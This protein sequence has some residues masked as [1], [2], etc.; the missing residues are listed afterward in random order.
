M[1]YPFRS[2]SIASG[3]GDALEEGLRTRK[4]ILAVERKVQAAEAG[5][6]RAQGEYWPQIG[7]SALYSWNDDRFAGGHGDSYTLAAMA[8]W[9]LWNWGATR[10]RVGRSRSDYR[11]ALESQ[12]S[13]RQQVEFEIRQAW[14]AVEEVRA[15]HE[16]SLAGVRAAEKALT[17]LEDRF[18]QGLT[19]TTDLLDAETMAHEA[20]VREMQTRYDLQ[21]ALRTLRYAIGLSPIPEVAAMNSSSL[22]RTYRLFA[23]LVLSIP[24]AAA[25]GCGHDRMPKS[26]EALPVS[27]RVQT[28]AS[29]NRERLGRGGRIAQGG[30]GSDDLRQGDG[31]GHGDPE[32]CR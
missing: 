16:V 4:D 6:G 22:I 17:I 20:R 26:E 31:N 9:Q 25:A 11:A 2:D 15:S 32:A 19:K 18:N 14:Q 30:A 3:L 8:Q 13:Y 23:F 5:I 29:C 24:L 1:I 10:T 12:R 7:A 21:K 28:L 27:V